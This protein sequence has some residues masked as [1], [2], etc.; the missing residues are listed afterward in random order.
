MC[1]RQV[2]KSYK[3]TGNPS[4][5]KTSP[6]LSSFFCLSFFFCDS[7]MTW[8]KKTLTTH[9]ADIKTYST[10]LAPSGHERRNG[11]DI[12]KLSSWLGEPTP[13]HPPKLL[14]LSLNART[15]NQVNT[16]QV[17]VEVRL[18]EGRRSAFHNALL[19]NTIITT[20]LQ[21]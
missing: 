11:I 18:P 17:A 14:I 6:S 4:T 16:K 19:S 20:V 2:F 9:V 15:V 1:T 7:F 12:L 8:C 21:N 10:L 3:L 5:S 13:S